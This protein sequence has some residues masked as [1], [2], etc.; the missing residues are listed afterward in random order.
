MFFVEQK[1]QLE[2][3]N[4]TMKNEKSLHQVLGRS[5]LCFKPYKNCKL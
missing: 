5:N 1:Y 4:E 2:N 3:K